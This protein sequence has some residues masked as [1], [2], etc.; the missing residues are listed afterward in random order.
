M[1]TG[2]K[3]HVRGWQGPHM[4]SR[5]SYTFFSAQGRKG[6]REEMWQIGKTYLERRD[7]I[8]NTCSSCSLPQIHI[9]DTM[10]TIPTASHLG[11]LMRKPGRR[12]TYYFQ[13]CWFPSGSPNNPIPS[14]T[15][16]LS[17]RRKHVGP[18][19]LLYHLVYQSDKVFTKSN[20]EE[21]KDNEVPSVEKTLMY[22]YEDIVI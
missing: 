15:Y 13:T 14:Q 4:H 3:S 20:K 16:H 17:Q 2:R 7:G 22:S 8:R 9:L 18:S 19:A 11:Q 1:L 5:G 21:F 6:G 12:V 10:R